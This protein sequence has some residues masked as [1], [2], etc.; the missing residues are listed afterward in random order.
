MNNL[1]PKFGEVT[2][3]D[4]TKDSFFNLEIPIS[5]QSMELQNFNTLVWSLELVP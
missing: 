3:I 1:K 4:E 5:W 2:V